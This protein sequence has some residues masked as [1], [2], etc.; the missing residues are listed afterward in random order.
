MNWILRSYFSDH[1][2]IK[3]WH[4][5]CF[6]IKNKAE[7]R[8]KKPKTTWQLSNT[9]F[10]CLSQILLHITR[11]LI[12]THCNVNF[13]V[14]PVPSLKCLFLTY[15]SSCFHSCSC[16]QLTEAQKNTC[17]KRSGFRWFPITYPQ[18]LFY[19]ERTT[20]VFITHG[21]WAV[22]QQY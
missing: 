15:V 21:I 5:L 8:W 3:I 4:Q 10:L 19:N 2:G 13:N 17:F 20:T 7:N 18:K 22:K 14:N 6:D 9:Y 1:K 16:C 12:T 11:L